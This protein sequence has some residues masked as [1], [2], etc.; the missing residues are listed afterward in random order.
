MAEFVPPQ[1]EVVIAY[2]DEP[3]PGV[4]DLIR[5]AYAEVPHWTKTTTLYH[6][7]VRLDAD[8]ADGGEIVSAQEVDRRMG[9]FVQ[10]KELGGM[11]DTAIATKNVG[12]DGGT[13]LKHMWVPRI[14]RE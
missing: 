11:V 3:L 4:Q 8:P 13:H 1:L 6:K 9:K 12:R 10:A 5:R 7:G 14:A 2:Y